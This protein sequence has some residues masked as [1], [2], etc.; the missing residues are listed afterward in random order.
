[1]KPYFMRLAHYNRWANRRLY[2]AAASLNDEAYRR[3]MDAFFG[4]LHGTLNHVLV[5]DR[6]W[7]WRMT[8]E[9]TAP[10]RLDAI[11]YDDFDAL[12]TA[13]AEEDER[14]LAV[15]EN[16]SDD[17]LAGALGYR[18]MAGEARRTALPIVL[19]HFFNH[20]THHRGQAH[21]LLGQLGQKPPPLDLIYFDWEDA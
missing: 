19:G 18:N 3:E 10:D 13:R 4:S 2:E 21:C 8:G 11:L 12:R 17:D 1:M 20:Q 7:L 16:Y 14:I 15:I 6:V 5:G 9:G